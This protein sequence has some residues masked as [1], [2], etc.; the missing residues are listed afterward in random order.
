MANL[1]LYAYLRFGRQF[2]QDLK[3]N[4]DYYMVIFISY[5]IPFG[6]RADMGRGLIWGMIC[7]LPYRNLFIIHFLSDKFAYLIRYAETY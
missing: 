2:L 6:P 7:N 4:R 5:P 1:N 3:I